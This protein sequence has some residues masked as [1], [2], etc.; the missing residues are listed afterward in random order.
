MPTTFTTDVRQEEGMNA[1]GLQVPAEVVIT[2]NSGKRPKVK[3]TV[4]GYTYRSTVAA[5]GDV[6]M[7]PLSKA[8]REAAGLQA[9]DEVEVTLESDT[10]PR[11]IEVPEDLATALDEGGVTAVFNA[12]A[13]SKRK[14]H[15]RQVTTAKAE[16]T[17]RRR[18]ARI[19]ATL[20][21]S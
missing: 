2:L 6:F 18:I 19:I 14:E 1:T 7:L 17:R 16:E 9:G 3:V 15:V 4:N 20:S 11:I 10:E 5:Y 13:P 12:L 8:H 21:K